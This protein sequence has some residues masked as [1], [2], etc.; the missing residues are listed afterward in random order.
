MVVGEEAVATPAYKNWKKNFPINQI[1]ENQ[2]NFNNPIYI[3][4]EFE[5]QAKYDV[6]NFH[7]TFIDKICSYYGVDDKYVQ[8]MRCSTRKYVDKYQEGK[9]HFVIREGIWI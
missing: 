8:I 2:F 7:K 9:I 3:W 4:L 1:P 5:H 6:A